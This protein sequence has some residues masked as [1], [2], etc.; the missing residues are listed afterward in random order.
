MKKT[1]VTEQIKIP[2]GKFSSDRDC[3]RCINSERSPGSNSG[4]YCNRHGRHTRPGID[5]CG[6]FED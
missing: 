6:Y 3:R 1:K 4:W 5:E 2:K